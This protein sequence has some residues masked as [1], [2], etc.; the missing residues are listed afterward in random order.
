MVGIVLA[1]FNR[2]F[3][4]IQAFASYGEARSLVAVV[5]FSRFQESNPFVE[6]VYRQLV[7]VVHTQE[8]IF[9]KYVAGLTFHGL[10]LFGFITEK[11]LTLAA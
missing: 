5:D 3:V 8:I 10:C 1:L 4:N 2:E 7:E 9:W 11:D 6:I